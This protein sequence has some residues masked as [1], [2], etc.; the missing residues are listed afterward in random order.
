MVHRILVASYTSEIYTLAFD[1][2]A[3]S[4][5]LTSTITVGHHP[6][7]ITAHPADKSIAYTALEQSEGRIIALKLDGEGRATAIGEGPSGGADPCSL[8]ALDE[9]LLLGNYSSGTFAAVPLS[10]E[11][12]YIVAAK[13]VTV[14]FTG[15]G[16]NKDRQEGSH[17]HQVIPHPHYKELLIPDLGAD[18]TRRLVRDGDG[19]W[20]EKGVISYK[21]GAGPRHVAFYEDVVY[22]LLELTS[23]VV[24][25]RVPPLPQEPI[26]LDTISTMATPPPPEHAAYMLAAEILIPAPNSSY[27]TPYIYVSNRNDPSPEGDTIAIF[28]TVDS[29]GKIGYVTEV[30]S[31]LKHLRGMVFG[32]PDDK[33]LIAGGV[34]GGGVKIFERV[35]GG[36]SLRE[37]ASIDL[38]APTGFL[39]L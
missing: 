32:G 16:P 13:T 1:Q 33:Y 8:V 3:P 11:P 20:A 21:A 36:R 34:H 15:T 17:L 4:L 19:T 26:L 22:T 12:P 23:E 10:L 31:G 28:S 27:H 5:T 38:A 18:K 9:E 30:R 35:D 2:Q 37:I 29:K 6:S 24:A 14:P 25:H 7:W 39:W